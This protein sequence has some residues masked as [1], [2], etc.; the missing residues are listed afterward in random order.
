MR[1]RGSTNQGFNAR[2]TYDGEGKSLHSS[3][4]PTGLESDQYRLEQITG[5]SGRDL[6]FKKMKLIQFFM[7]LN[8]LRD[9][10]KES[11]GINP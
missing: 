9:L 3:C 7:C 6:F 8:I 10:H 2:E 5:L 1:K 11:L 4:A